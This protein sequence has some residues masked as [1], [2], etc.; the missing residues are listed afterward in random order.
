MTYTFLDYQRTLDITNSVIAVKFSVAF[1]IHPWPRILRTQL[2]PGIGNDVISNEP[3]RN[4]FTAN[5][6]KC[7]LY[8]RLRCRPATKS[9]CCEDAKLRTRADKRSG[10]AARV[11]SPFCSARAISTLS[12]WSACWT[13]QTLRRSPGGRCHNCISGFD[14]ASVYC[15]SWR[16]CVLSAALLC[17][18][19]G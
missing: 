18:T 7:R 13:S 14:V 2:C 15:R 10:A 16:A 12:F 17:M 8:Y 6:C 19:R 1:Q 4:Y 5:V 3:Q 9:Q 11:T